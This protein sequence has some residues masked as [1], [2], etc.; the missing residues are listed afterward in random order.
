[1]QQLDAADELT[2]QAKL[3]EGDI[4]EKERRLAKI[5]EEIRAANYEGHLA[6]LGTKAHTLDAKRAELDKEFTSLNL[7]ADSRAR[8]DL[9]REALRSKTTEVKNL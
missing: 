5:H 7:Q 3:I 6:E 1:M 4:E 2:S 8:L 9:K